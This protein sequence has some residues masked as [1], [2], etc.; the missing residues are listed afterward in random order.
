M[1]P[2]RRPPRL[3]APR[4]VA[5]RGASIE[6]RLSR[7]RVSGRATAVGAK[8]FRSLLARIV[9]G[10]A[11]ALRGI[12]AFAGVTDDEVVVAVRATFG[13]SAVRPEIDVA[14]T[15]RGA[16]DAAAAL[17]AVGARGGSV[18]A[19]TARPASLLGLQRALASFGARSGA[20]R[21]VLDDSPELVLDGR[22][23]RRLRWVDGVAC[24][25][26]GESLLATADPA[27][28]DELLFSVPRPDLVVADGP[29]A[30]AATAAG[31]PVVATVGLE[32]AA[33]AVAARRSGAVTVVPVDPT[34]PPA[35]YEPLLEHLEAL[36]S[37]AASDDHGAPALAHQPT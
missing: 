4:P 11:I 37:T 31:L 9:A 34:G 7:A 13:A 2:S 12:P 18:V 19:A 3:D 30:L 10:D 26:D 27:A 5:V 28:A 33:L 16:G 8:E 24:V 36:A 20:H 1:S 15:L 21:V 22:R 6:E 29:F 35:A 14:A 32:D 25:T 17:A 23:G